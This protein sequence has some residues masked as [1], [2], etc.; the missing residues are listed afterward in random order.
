[1][2]GNL[3]LEHLSAFHHFNFT[4]RWSRIS[5][6]LVG[7]LCANCWTMVLIIISVLGIVPLWECW[8]LSVTESRRNF[9]IFSRYW[10]TKNVASYIASTLTTDCHITS[11]SLAGERYFLLSTCYE[12]RNIVMKASETYLIYAPMFY[13]WHRRCYIASANDWE[14]ISPEI[15]VAS[16]CRS[17]PEFDIIYVRWILPINFPSQMIHER[18]FLGVYLFRVVSD[19]IS[20]LKQSRIGRLTGVISQWE[21]N[22]TESIVDILQH[23][24]LM[25]LRLGKILMLAMDIGSSRSNKNWT[26][27]RPPS[28]S[29]FSTDPLHIINTHNFKNMKWNEVIPISEILT[30]YWKISFLITKPCSNPLN[31][32]LHP[33]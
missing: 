19:T 11:T 27:K 13:R 10:G 15:L 22:G 12:S 6:K 14:P 1:M 25:G 26:S 17:R 21:E 9:L 33:S 28:V 5:I 4:K 16:G 31:L 23:R 30:N 7:V 2:V 18:Y 8:E 32:F 24:W 3:R 29:T 20:H